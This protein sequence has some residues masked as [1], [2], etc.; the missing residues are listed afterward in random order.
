MSVLTNVSEKTWIFSPCNT[1]Y[2]LSHKTSLLHTRE[3]CK[4]I[5]CNEIGFVS[6]YSS[7]TDSFS[8]CEGKIL[9]VWSVT[10]LIV[11]FINL[12]LMQADLHKGNVCYFCLYSR[13]ENSPQLR[14]HWLTNGGR[15]FGKWLRPIETLWDGRSV[16]VFLILA[17]LAGNFD[18]I[19]SI[20]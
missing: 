4:R 6:F 20:V 1:K 16:C 5:R 8:V 17:N 19:H 2:H 12:F 9:V 15:H 11:A 18:I 7:F 10:L 13:I 3:V 14:K